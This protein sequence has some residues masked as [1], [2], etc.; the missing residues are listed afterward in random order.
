MRCAFSAIPENSCS[1][2]ETDVEGCGIGKEDMVAKSYLCAIRRGENYEQ[3]QMYHFIVNGTLGRDSSEKKVSE[4]T[5][6]V[7]EAAVK[8]NDG[9]FSRFDRLLF[10]PR[11]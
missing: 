6:C 10:S 8:V 1:L 4:G 5:K 3:V 2:G 9:H 11:I 7:R